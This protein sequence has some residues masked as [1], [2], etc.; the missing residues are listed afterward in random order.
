MRILFSVA[1]LLAPLL[2]EAQTAQFASRAMIASNSTPASEAGIEI[3]KKGGNA[4]DAAVATGFALAVTLPEAGNLGGGGYMVIRMADGT[5]AAL[6]FRETAPAAA[7][8]DMYVDAQGKVTSE[9]MVGYKAAGVPGSVAGLCAAQERFGK[10]PLATVMEPAIRLAER[11][12]VVDSFTF[13]AI[14]KSAS[15]LEQFAGKS[16]FLPKGAP[17]PIGSK[18]VQP[19]LAATLRLIA[20]EG[21]TAFY[22]GDIARMIADDMQRNGGLITM[23]DL[24]AYQPLW[25]DPVRTP[26]HKHTILGMPLSSS[27]GLTMSQIF[28]AM[29]WALPIRAP[30]GMTYMIILGNAMRSAFKYRNTELGDTTSQREGTETTHYSVVDSAGNAV[31]TTTTINSLFGAGAYVASAGFFLN[32]EMDDFTVRPGVPNQFGLIMGDQN[33]IAPGKRPLSS[34][35]PTIVLDKDNKVL[36]VAGS[37]GGPRIITSTVQVILNVIDHKMSLADAMRAGRI[38]HQQLPDTLL[39]EPGWISPATADSLRLA[40]VAI[41]ETPSVGLVDAVLRVKGGY[42]GMDDPR[43]QVKAVGY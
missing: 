10:L 43:R 27:G 5:E 1:L 20:K 42:E 29:E 17:P 21:P 3:L 2:T 35:S 12:F 6:D 30:Q 34:M 36:L 16:V 31:A 18:L 26:Y 4:V 23:Q 8:R 9:S 40:G 33:A 19:A 14:A 15:L 41:K 28:Q 32:N 24:A 38:H 11:G 7:S 22:Q 25:K 13:R 37:R 39:Y